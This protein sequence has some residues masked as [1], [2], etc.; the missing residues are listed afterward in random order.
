MPP[1]F[2]SAARLHVIAVIRIAAIDDDVVRGEQWQ[3]VARRLV[4][5]QWTGSA[6]GL[7]GFNIFNQTL[8]M[9]WAGSRPLGQTSDP[10][11]C[12]AGLK[13]SRLQLHHDVIYLSGGLPSRS[14]GL[15]INPAGR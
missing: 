9:A 2:Q 12:R 6:P 4:D 5:D 7:S 13:S 11:M 3:R 8:S 10:F 15:S 14:S 1:A